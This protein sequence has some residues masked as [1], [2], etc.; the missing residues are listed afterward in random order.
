MSTDFHTYKELTPEQRQNI[1]SA[2]ASNDI[3]AIADNTPEKVEIGTDTRGGFHWC[4][5]IYKNAIKNGCVIYDEYGKRYS[6]NQ[7]CEYIGEKP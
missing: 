3:Q 1:I 6:Y 7:F 4:N 5:P 2:V